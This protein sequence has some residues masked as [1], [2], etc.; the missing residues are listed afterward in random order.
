MSPEN[1]QV[2]RRAG[3]LAAAMNARR[4]QRARLRA[5]FF[6]RWRA[7]TLSA[8]VHDLVVEGL[9]RGPKE[10]NRMVNIKTYTRGRGQ[11]PQLQFLP[12]SSAYFSS[13]DFQPFG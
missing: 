5:A 4:V 9:L 3:A 1:V 7:T 8:A 10:L 11:L 2:S 6:S 12:D 13:A